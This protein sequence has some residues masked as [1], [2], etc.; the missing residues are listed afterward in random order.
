MENNEN[1]NVWYNLMTTISALE[2]NSIQIELAKDENELNDLN[3]QRTK[4]LEA[5]ENY[6]V[7]LCSDRSE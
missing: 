1:K 3:I 2:S 4:L 5:R 7:T 6:L